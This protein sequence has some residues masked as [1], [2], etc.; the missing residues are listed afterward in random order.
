MK[1][2]RLDDISSIIDFCDYL[3]KERISFSLRYA[4]DASVVC[5]F[6][7]AGYR[8]EV[9]FYAQTVNFC[10]FSGDESTRSDFEALFNLVA[11]DRDG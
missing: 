4:G 2:P 1:L 10:V 9:S 3:E 11:R 8:V 7:L 5:S 6:I